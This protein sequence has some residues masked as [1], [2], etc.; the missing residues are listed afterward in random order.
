MKYCS[1]N[2]RLLLF[3]SCGRSK[4]KVAS[5]TRQKKKEKTR[6]GKALKGLETI[7]DNENSAE[8]PVDGSIGWNQKQQK[9][10]ETAL[11]QY[12]KGSLERWERI[13]KVVPD[14]TKVI[15]NS[16][17]LKRKSV[18]YGFINRR[19]ACCESNIY[20]NW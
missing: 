17:S 4:Q 13:A 18:S 9:A 6:G 20:L 3:F 8:E 19:N 1:T 12:P 10:L 5:A 14:K 16:L 15:R 2:G 7:R 11:A